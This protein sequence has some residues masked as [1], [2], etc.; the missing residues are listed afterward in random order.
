MKTII[1]ATALAALASPAALLGAGAPVH[2]AD[3]SKTPEGLSH[4]DWSGIRG[5]YER[6]RHAVVANS[7]GTHQARNPGQA[8]LTKF[9]GRGFI[10]TPDAGGWSW[11]LELAGYG[12][13]TEVRQDGGK[14]S[15]VRGGGLTEWF[16]NDARGLEQGWTLARRPEHVGIDGPIRLH[17]AVRGSLRPQVS[18]EGA[19]VAFM[20][21]AGSAALTYGGL[22][23]WDAD[24]KVVQARFADGEVADTSLCVVVDDKDARYP[25]TIDPIAQQ[26]YLK[27]SNPDV[28]DFFGSCVA[29][30]GDTVVVGARDE[31]S[32]ATGVNGIQ[33]DNSASNSG[34][35]YVFVRSE[36][37]WSQ[38]AYLKASN[39]GAGDNFGCDVAISGDT[40]VIGAWYENSSATGVN[41][42]QADNSASASG[43]AY[44]FVRTGTTWSQQAYLK[45]SK[46]GAVD[47][48]GL[49]VAVSGDT[50]VVGARGEDSNATGV[51]GN[52]ADNSASSS[53]AAYVFVRS[54]TTWTQ[55]AYLKAS[56][57]EAGD[58]FGHSVAVSNDTVVVGAYEDSSA[59][60]VNGDQSDN[61][62]AN[63]GAAYV[64][65]RSGTTW[66]QQAYLKA[67]NTGA[68]DVFGVTVAASGN[69]LVIGTLGESSSATGVNGDQMNDLALN[70]GA[71]YVFVRSGANWSQQAY[72][73]ASNTEAG[74]YF[75]VSVA[76]AGDTVLV[77]AYGEDS[78]A[79]GVNGIQ[80]NNEAQVSGAAYLFVRSGTTW[81][82]QA[83]LKPSNT[84][85]SDLFGNSVAV[86]GDTVVVGAPGESS[87]AMGANGNQSDNSVGNSG[88]AY[89]FDV[90][91]KFT[92]SV[93]AVHGSTIGAG[94]Y[95]VGSTA[96]LAVTVNPG[97]LFAGWTGD[98]T[99]N[100][101]PLSVL[102]DADK[103]I[104]ANFT[105]DTNDTDDDGLTNYQEIVEYGTN[106]AKQDTDNDGVKDST[107]AL[108][109][110][111]TE[112][113][114][115]DHDGIGD[116]TE[117][118]DDN[119]GLS[120]VD[121][122]NTHH[123]NPKLADSDGDGLS[124]PD[125]LQVHTTNPNIADTD[126]DGL[127]DGEEILTHH[128]NPK[129]NDTDADGFLDGYEVLTG[130]SP[131]D[132][133]DHPALVAEA[134]TAI[135]FT[136]PAALGKTYRI[137][138]S[139]DL[140]TWTTVES[141]IA[142]TGQLIQR[143][144]TTRGMPMRYFRVEEDGS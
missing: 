135:E 32:S 66:T 143:F 134:R 61:S 101:N 108:P 77:G 48:F 12:E 7:D 76:V 130:K 28:H 114:D 18:G 97:Y 129:V 10:V 87:N 6:Q 14:I 144:Y 142:G 78:N 140:A 96:T 35:A 93:S 47:Q 50:V 23:A 11:G 31:D 9:D 56:N 92:L 73:K 25:I 49:A 19:S 125:E 64:F 117:T 60:G 132:I 52:Q 82:Q 55:Q 138:D 98:A 119:D 88:A 42:N 72:L 39:T 2:P 3:P 139:P 13:V 141:G 34:A 68:F 24:G 99:G 15:Y 118:D 84:G 4:S 33:D 58:L 80:S 105:P 103:T 41:G 17:L 123:T 30:S 126:N 70:S 109:L 121:E 95:D 62:A 102:M 107:D 75:G 51:N 57:T 116:N 112:T 83:Y 127:N 29:A 136:F 46:T 63:A 1:F 22:K 27:A 37:A 124:D 45:A 104:T 36:G 71:A 69:T 16:V 59:I 26:A 131:L 91:A 133:A 21:E 74:D 110:D 65:V 111:P 106:P 8:W 20:S 90:P 81:S 122:I 79:A 54:G 113:L 94:D 137:E 40:I 100:A 89:V 38:Q 53:G 86:S 128:T 115:S 44:V 85:A 5:A 120:D 43:A 67:S